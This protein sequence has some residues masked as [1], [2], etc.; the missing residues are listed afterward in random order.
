MFKSLKELY[1]LLEPAQ[2]RRLKVLQVLIILMSIAE[3]IGV[4]SIGPFM[5]LVG[6]LNQLNG[7]GLLAQAYQ[8]SGVASHAQFVVLAGA[9]SLLALT[10][11]ALLSM[12]TLWRLSRY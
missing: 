9:F 6:N 4:M 12:Y 1:G 3:L 8:W 5:A 2:R 11:S 7:D 10:V